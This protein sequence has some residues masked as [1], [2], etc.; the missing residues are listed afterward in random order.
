MFFFVTPINFFLADYLDAPTLNVTCKM[1]GAIP[2][3]VVIR[4]GTYRRSAYI[5]DLSFNIALSKVHRARE[6]GV[7]TDRDSLV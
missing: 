2:A 7:L 3:V 5:N 1:S 4:D 6:K